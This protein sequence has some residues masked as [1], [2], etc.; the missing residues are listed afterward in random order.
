MPTT[1]D[2]STMGFVM[3]PI[4]C[5]TIGFALSLH[6]V[7]GAEPVRL[8]TPY[9][10]TDAKAVVLVPETTNAVAYSLKTITTTGW[11]P[12]KDNQGTVAAG[13]LE[14]APLTEGIHILTLNLPK[15]VELRFLAL[16]PPA[17]LDPLA[18]RRALPRQGDRLLRGEPFTILAMGDSVTATGDYPEIL[19]LLLERAT[20]QHNVTVVK[21]AYSGRSVD[22]TVRNF[23]D[24]G[25][26]NKPQLGL[27]MYGLNDQGAGIAPAAY[28][29]QCRWVVEHMAQEC[30]ADSVLLTPT[31]DTSLGKDAIA[32]SPYLFRTLGFAA[33]L[34]NLGREL[35]VPVADT[36]H[37]L[38]G[39]GGATVDACGRAMW[40]V[41]PPSYHKQFVSVLESAGKGDGVH[42]NVL[43]HLALARA[44]FNAI[45][46]VA[47]TEHI[48]G[49]SE[50]T[51]AGLVS[52]VQLGT[53]VTVFPLPDDVVEVRTGGVCWP[54]RKQP[55]DL[56]KYPANHY[57][58]PMFVAFVAG[59][60]QIVEAPVTATVDF[61][62][63]RQVVTGSTVTVKFGNSP[64]TVAIPTDSDVGRIPLIRAMQAA[65][66]AYVRF[67]A[68]R[69]S[70]AIVDGDLSEWNE[71]RWIPVGESVQARG[72][73]GV[74]DH[75][76]ATNE[77]YLNWAFKAGSNGVFMAAKLTG[78]VDKDSFTLFFDPRAP[79]LL[80]TPGRYYW[81]SGHRR[82][83]GKL[84]L[85][86]G[87]TSK[88][89]PGLVG[90]WRDAALELFIPY[91]LME[92]TAW[93]T[94]GDLG[95]SIWWTHVGPDGQKTNL[96]WS[97]DGHPWNPR[98]YGVVRLGADS[99]TNLPYMVRVK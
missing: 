56:L 14:I 31:P 63:E 83:D 39:P 9:V 58:T 20:G 24:D 6:S 40:P 35:K 86:R 32:Y 64:V 84:E 82:A 76:T 2:N 59:Q 19:K 55:A 51:P 43:G 1:H 80:G 30:A 28:L 10:F 21:R 99:P 87:E 22:A 33:L 23:R 50:W 54:N 73:R 95:L 89:A 94:A 4:I 38:W 65:E 96:Y 25:P 17:R 36:F 44:V 74:T 53:N 12:A 34:E 90:V 60:P 78:A 27:L 16:A 68:A 77:C 8:A 45:A 67:G 46:G 79:E 42:P 13:K 97:E 81:L 85:K 91:E 15:P 98:W 88:S 57:P 92:L 49:V 37:A 5:L 71:H 93:P 69:A 41:F 29:D 52:H 48:R 3:K 66:L 47:P 72:S 62:R 61:V 18:V 11:G 7:A 70:E 75:R 26:P